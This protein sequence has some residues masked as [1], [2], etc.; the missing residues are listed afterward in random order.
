[1]KTYPNK[2]KLILLL[3]LAVIVAG[4]CSTTAPAPSVGNPSPTFLPTFTDSPPKQP[5][6]TPAP[7]NVDWLIARLE[8]LDIDAFFETSFNEMSM[9]DPESMVGAGFGEFLP[10]VTLTDIS[11]DYLR[12]TQQVEITILAMLQDYDRDSLTPE[13][14]V[15]YDVY[16]WYLEDLVAGHEFMYYNYPATYFPITSVPSQIMDFFA[17]IHP[18]NTLQD[19]EDYLTRLALVENKMDQLMDGLLRR[20]EIGVIPPLIIF[21]WTLYGLRELTSASATAMPF[22]TAFA[23]KLNGLEGLSDT[24]MVALL[25]R[26]E[27]IITTSVLPSYQELVSYLENLRDSASP[28]DGF[29]QFENGEEFYAYILRSHNSTDMSAD[30]I[31]QLGLQE[32][33]RI[34]AEMEVLFAELGISE[35]LDLHTA[36]NQVISMG[37]VVPMNQVV[38]AYEE[39]IETANQRLVEAF[40]VFP[41]FDVVVIGAAFGGYY[42]RGTVDGSRPGAFYATLDS[43][44]EPIYQ[45]KS[46]AYHEAVPGHHLQISLAQEMNLPTFRNYVG[47]NGYTEGWALYAEK[48]AWELGWYEDDPYGN[49]GRLQYEAFRAARLVVDTGIHAQG[50]SFDQAVDF[51]VDNVGHDEGYAEGQIARYVVWPGQ[52][53]SYMVGMLNILE[54]RQLAM[55][56]LGD[57]F[58]LI[59]FHRIVL[60]NGS[61]PLAV[62]E[63]VVENYVAEK[64]AGASSPAVSELSASALL[65]GIALTLLPA[66][67]GRKKTLRI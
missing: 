34:H 63:R 4:G 7:I 1:M 45:M 35:D 10:E 6:S 13:Q 38:S 30:E 53:T 49:L 41:R 57:D 61:M 23:E 17:E 59:E 50:W 54:L 33:D 27:M 3:L 22:Y 36:F 18:L 29:G 40:D 55:D 65:F 25:V 39:I 31:H 20:E 14:Q 67:K 51:W 28:G 32:L 24:D 58:D 52:S 56:Q 5:T 60:S 26:A 44:G 15:S 62:L 16:E 47:F 21:D 48:L 8:G 19:A 11:D 46:L 43:R 12:E 42:Q 9:R 2:L 37:G 64:L 66:L